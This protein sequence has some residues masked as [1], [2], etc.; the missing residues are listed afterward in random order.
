MGCESALGYGGRGRIP[1]FDITFRTTILNHGP[2]PYNKAACGSFKNAIPNHYVLGYF[3]T[4][5]VKDHFGADA[6][7]KILTRAY[8]KPPIPFS[9]S[10]SMKKITGMNAVQTYKAMT[11]EVKDLWSKQ[12]ENINETPVT[13]YTHANNKAFTNYKFPQFINDSTIVAQKAGLSDGSFL[14]YK[15]SIADE[16]WFVLLNK[17]GKEKRLCLSGVLDDNGMMSSAGN[18]IVWTEYTYDP[19]WGAKNFTVIK[20]LDASTGKIKQLTHRSRLHAPLF[21]SRWKNN[22]CY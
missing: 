10:R 4:T 16:Y 8:T 14:A 1:S 9:F 20:T 5:Y 18:K 11:T 15:S 2:F 22:C 13:Y 17:K 7:N 19:R 3:M 6:W 12:I 21:F